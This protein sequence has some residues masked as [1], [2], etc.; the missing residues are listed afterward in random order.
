MHTGIETFRRPMMVI[1]VSVGLSTAAQAQLAADRSMTGAPLRSAVEYGLAASPP[2]AEAFV[3]SAFRYDTGAVSFR[4]GGSGNLYGAVEGGSLSNDD[5]RCMDNAGHWGTSLHESRLPGGCRDPIPEG[6]LCIAGKI[7]CFGNDGLLTN[8]GRTA[9]EPTLGQYA[10]R[11]LGVSIAMNAGYGRYAPSPGLSYGLSMSGSAASEAGLQVGVAYS[12]FAVGLGADIDC[13]GTE[14]IA[15]EQ[16]RDRMLRSG[17]TENWGFVGG[18]RQYHDVLKSTHMEPVQSNEPCWYTDPVEGCT[19]I[20]GTGGKIVCEGQSA[21]G[22]DAWFVPE[23]PDIH[24]G[25]GEL[26]VT[27]EKGLDDG[28]M[29]VVVQ[30]Y[31]NSNIFHDETI[32][33][34][35]TMFHDRQVNLMASYFSFGHSD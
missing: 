13:I 25:V 3:A 33:K 21:R 7:V 20:P 26:Y 27:T 9:Y 28:S 11:K 4:F 35:M 5:A 6:C 24:S 30:D 16:N 18:V 19:C 1:L 15:A 14:D 32:A 23:V 22:F 12:A 8:I 31:R 2:T 34:S 10:R 29:G 17:V